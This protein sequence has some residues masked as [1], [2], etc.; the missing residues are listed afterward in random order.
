MV[1]SNC[2]MENI[3]TSL[4]FTDGEIIETV[5]YR[6]GISEKAITIEKIKFFLTAF[7]FRHKLSG[8]VSISIKN[9]KLFM[10]CN[11]KPKKFGIE[12]H[13]KL[14]ARYQVSCTGKL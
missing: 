3:E 2:L 11:V 13:R 10:E 4:S 6:S 12:M 1:K 9:Q 5:K 14:L 8:K 7:I